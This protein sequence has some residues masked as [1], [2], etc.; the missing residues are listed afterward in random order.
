ME[1]P[2]Q[3]GIY[4]KLTIDKETGINET[5]IH[6]IFQKY[7]K[8]YFGEQFLNSMLPSFQRIGLTALIKTPLFR[9]DIFNEIRRVIISYGC[10][11]RTVLATFVGINPF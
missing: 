4:I 5:H 2:E 8:S 3:F 7:L 9:D 10:C 1:A 11:T 6:Q